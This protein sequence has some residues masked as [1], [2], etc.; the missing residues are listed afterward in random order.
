MPLENMNLPKA[1]RWQIKVLK[2]I[3]CSWLQPNSFLLMKL[4]LELKNLRK[5]NEKI[6]EKHGTSYLSSEKGKYLGRYK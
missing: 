4:Y 3:Y 6:W 2:G 5:E 1:K